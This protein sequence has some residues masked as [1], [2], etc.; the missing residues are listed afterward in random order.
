MNYKDEQKADRGRLRMCQ[1]L[2]NGYIHNPFVK[3][4]RNLWCFCGSGKKF[5]KC[6]NGRVLEAVKLKGNEDLKLGFERTVKHVTDMW[7]DFGIIYKK[8]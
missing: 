6:C 1:A 8:I 2:K 3:Y 4:P 7:D 5:K